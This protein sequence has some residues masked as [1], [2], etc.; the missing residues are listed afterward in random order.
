MSYCAKI[1]EENQAAALLHYLGISRTR[2]GYWYIRWIL[3]WGRQEEMDEARFYTRLVRRCK[4]PRLQM[5]RDMY[6]ALRR[7]DTLR[8]YLEEAESVQAGVWA[9]LCVLSRWLN[10]Y[11]AE[12]PEGHG[13]HGLASAGAGGA[14]RK[15]A[16]FPRPFLE[17]TGERGKL[18]CLIFGWIPFWRCAATGTTRG[19][20]RS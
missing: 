8:N 10:R 18:R 15:I 11:E 16:P 1:P 7:V 12:L 17:Y 5:A 20:R 2:K 6:R 4:V 3:E 19:R 9:L 13:R 14:A